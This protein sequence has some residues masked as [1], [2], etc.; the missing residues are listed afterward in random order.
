LRQPNKTK[1]NKKIIVSNSEKENTF[2][3]QQREMVNKHKR[4]LN[5]NSLFSGFCL[6]LFLNKAP[7]KQGE[8]D[9]CH[10]N[11]E[12]TNALNT[13]LSGEID[14]HHQSY[15]SPSSSTPS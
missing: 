5:G 4:E 2:R 12:F 1:Q 11:L 7:G 13:H 3:I 9:N 14:P 15:M 8:N 6:N 10:C